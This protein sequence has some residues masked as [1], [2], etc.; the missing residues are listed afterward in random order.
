MKCLAI[1]ALFLCAF[2]L[3]AQA[4]AASAN[5]FLG[6]WRLNLEKS[7]FEKSGT[8]QPGVTSVRQ[9]TRVAG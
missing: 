1:A 6:S 3:Q 4:P 8:P 9:Y 5:P 2:A 7:N